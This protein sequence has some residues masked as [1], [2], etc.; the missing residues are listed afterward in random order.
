MKNLIANNIKTA[1]L[2]LGLA[3]TN[4]TGGS[5]SFVKLSDEYKNLVV[6][7]NSASDHPELTQKE[8]EKIILGEKI[9]WEDGVKVKIA[10]LKTS[11]SVG[12]Q[13]AEDV[14]DMSPNEFNRYWLG[15][16]FEGKCDAPTFF[17]SEAELMQFIN[18]TPG[19]V[20]I[21]SSQTNIDSVAKIKII[22]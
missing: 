16:V 13:V 4:I 7:S 12:S 1:A 11:N 10:L 20:G 5:D 22:S 18:I 8:F 6:I 9:R 14:F 21:V 3:M 15:L 17:T 2:I 19:S